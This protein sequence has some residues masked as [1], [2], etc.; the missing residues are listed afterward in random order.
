MA[1]NLIAPALVDPLTPKPI[2]SIAPVKAPYSGPSINTA[3]VPTG[4]VSN[5]LSSGASSIPTYGSAQVP[6]AT[7]PKPTSVVS[8]APAAKQVTQI[9]KTMTDQSTAN[10][11]AANTPSPYND[12]RDANGLLLNPPGSLYDRNTGKL[13]NPPTATT[14]P[15]AEDR[16]VNAP[17]EGM[18]ESYYVKTGQR[19]DQP[20]GSLP[21]GYSSQNPST[22]TDVSNTANVGNGIQFK[23]FSDGTYGRFDASGNYSPA[24]AQAFQDAINEQSITDKIKAIQNGSYQ[25]PANQQSQLDGLSAKYAG[26][27]AQTQENYANAKGGAIAMSFM[28][29][30]AGTSIG[31]GSVTTVVNAGLKKV[32]DLQFELANGLATMQ[33]AFFKDDMTQ[34]KASYDSYQSNQSQVQNEIDKVTQYIQTQADKQDT[35]VQTKNMN[36]AL[37]QAAK[38]GD[39]GILPTDTPQQVDQKKQDNSAVYKYETNTKSG[40]IDHNALDGMISSYKKTGTVPSF[41]FGATGTPM[42]NAFWAAVGGVSGTIDQAVL[43]KAALGAST[44]ALTTQENQLAGAQTEIDQ[45]KNSL[46][47]ASGF[48]GKL[49]NTG[50]PI[51][52][53]YLNS[54]KTGVFGSPEVS[55]INTA[56]SAAA[57]AY[58]RIL[59]GA[60]A[61]IAGTSV[62]S[63]EEVKGLLN[64]A[65]SKGQFDAV[66]SVMKQDANARI[67]AQQKTIDSIKQDI[68]DIGTAPAASGSSSSSGGTTT[69]SPIKTSYGSINP[70]L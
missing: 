25:L 38:Y 29:G 2:A 37:Q 49:D 12:V 41:G 22:R 59:S 58:A 20:A 10:A 23:Q 66:M 19:S 24:T 55:A 61:S 11:T 35:M 62:S 27:I 13:L 5:P 53:K 46:D 48:E 4:S 70:S 50:S 51:V 39:A 56:V 26:L 36:Y 3:P 43:S 69:S 9:Q 68:L 60:S 65:M 40:G 52:Q 32:A 54:V 45:L 33:E 8:T 28:G 15:T 17:D 7:A 44:K 42:R 57:A 63:M 18:Q 47:I 31:D 67:T 30:T 1:N 16:I 21:A 14:A 34:L 6:A 64:S